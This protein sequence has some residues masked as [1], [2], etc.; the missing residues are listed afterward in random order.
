MGL[1]NAKKLTIPICILLTLIFEVTVAVL[2]YKEIGDSR[3]T[4]NIVRLII[5]L[6]LLF[7]ILS[8]KSRIP[9]Y[10][11]TF[12]HVII[13]LQFFTNDI[14]LTYAVFGLYHLII[15]LMIYFSDEIDLRLKRFSR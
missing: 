13:G 2:V 4:I 12:Y 5:Q 14:S 1:T 9:V 10:I 3:L 11:I 8:S 7:W 15:G 6:L